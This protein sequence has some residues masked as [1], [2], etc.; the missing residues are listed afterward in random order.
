MQPH[1]IIAQRFDQPDVGDRLLRGDRLF[2][3][4][5]QRLGVVPGDRG[6]Q[7]AGW[8]V[9]GPEQPI[10]PGSRH[11]GEQLLNPQPVVLRGVDG[12]RRSRVGKANGEMHSCPGRFADP[13]GVVDS[14]ATELFGE[15][16]LH[17]QPD[18]GGV[19]IAWQIDQAR[20]EVTE[21]VA[22]QEQQRAAARSEVDHRTGH[23]EQLLCAEREQLRPRDGRENVEY[24]LTGM[25][26]V[27]GAVL[28]RILHPPGHQRYFEDVGV[29]SGC[30]EQPHE[31][32]LDVGLL[33]DGEDV[34]IGAVPQE[35]GHGGLCQHQQA[36][37]AAEFGEHLGAQP[38]HTE[39][40]GLLGAGRSGADAAA[41]GAQQHEVPLTEPPQ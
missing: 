3:L 33:A 23:G 4:L 27:T 28:Q 21:L 16:V 1:R 29:A 17:G 40:T 10:G 14:S 35:A 6:I 15:N 41:L 11:R 25:A 20:H 32:V 2:E 31:S 5:G 13:G 12:V 9:D 36:T 30:G 37:V 18:R 8:V 34:G 26:R 38:G 39:T 19:A 24:Q 22:P 7:G